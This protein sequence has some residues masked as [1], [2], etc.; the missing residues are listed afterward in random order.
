MTT[1]YPPQDVPWKSRDFI[2]DYLFNLALY[3][4]EEMDIFPKNTNTGKITLKVLGRN[5]GSTGSR[6]HFEY[7]VVVRKG[8]PWVSRLV[9]NQSI[10][11]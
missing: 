1:A 2:Y 10:R 3:G 7:C 11:T 8:Q 6:C 4:S 5:G 9:C